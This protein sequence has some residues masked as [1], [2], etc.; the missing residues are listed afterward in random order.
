[1]PNNIDELLTL[2]AQFEELA[3]DET[4]V[5]EA[6]DRGTVIID[7]GHPKNKSNKQHFPANNANQARNALSR[8]NEYSSKPEWWSGTLQ[9]L[10][11]AVVRG[12]KK[13]YPSIEVSEAAKKPGKG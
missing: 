9:E 10:V 1:M 12:V 2:T 4:L 5:S 3:T 13:H 8:V 6:K 11:N 7:V